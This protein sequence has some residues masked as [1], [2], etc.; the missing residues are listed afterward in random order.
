MIRNII[1]DV[2]GIL[3]DDSKSNI[4]KV[5]NKNCDS[6]YKVSYGGTFRECLLGNIT[7]QEHISN[8]VGSTDFEDIKYILSKE[9]LSVTYPLVSENFEYIIE[10]KK[11]GYRLYLLTN[12]TEDTYQYV[13]SIMHIDSIFDG[14][15][16]SYQ[17]HMIKPN[18]NIYELIIERFDLNKEETIFFDDREKNVIAAQAVGINAVVFRTI[19]D[20]K[21][22][23]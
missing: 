9:N 23:I 21:N 8:L 12:I 17:E 6:I 3:F 22:N 11:Q 20:I 19:N 7:V 4:E 18:S 1:L 10:L 15:I 13:D 2:G 5:L 14:G 16:Y